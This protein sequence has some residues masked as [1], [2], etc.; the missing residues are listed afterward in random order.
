MCHRQEWVENGHLALLLICCFRSIYVGIRMYAKLVLFAAAT[1]TS[2]QLQAAAPPGKAVTDPRPSP[3]SKPGVTLTYLGTAGWR[4][5]DGR[6]VIIIDPYLSRLR[7]AETDAIAAQ[8]RKEG[9]DSRVVY[10]PND[11][12]V[13]DRA[14]IDAHVPRADYILVTHSHS[15]HLMD[16]PYLAGKTGATVLGTESTTNVVAA[17]GI[18]RSQLITVRGGEDYE[19]GS[20]S[21]RVIPSLHSALEDKRYSDP[22]VIPADIKAPL[23]NNQYHEGR[24]L[25]YLIRIGGHEILAFGGMNFIEKELSGLRPDV[26]ILGAAPSRNENHDYA[27]RLMRATCRPGLVL[28]THWDDH[29]MALADPKAT[30]DRLPR[31]KVFAGEIRAASPKTVVLVPKYFIPISL[32]SPPRRRAC[33]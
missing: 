7:R 13:P 23:S 6:T 5:S 4:I 10:A 21:V 33:N 31:L 16:V 15:D 24:T 28:P 9:G 26:A 30:E 8:W 3:A 18:P 17:Y 1:L 19:F 27:G 14:A 22:G 2:P 25:G 29:A 11:P 20:F 32:P 12:L